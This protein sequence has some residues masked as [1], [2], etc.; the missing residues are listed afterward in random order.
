MEQDLF[1]FHGSEVKGWMGWLL[2]F[3]IDTRKSPRI[4]QC[5]IPFSPS[6]YHIAFPYMHHARAYAIECQLLGFSG[7]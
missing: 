3:R 4:L 7:Q 2:L 1:Y 6:D 5:Q